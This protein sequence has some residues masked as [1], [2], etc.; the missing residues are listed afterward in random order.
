[1]KVAVFIS[2]TPAAKT[3]S[4]QGVGGG[5]IEGIIMA[6]NSC[7]SKRSRQLFIAGAVDPLHEEKLAPCAAEQERNQAAQRR[8]RRSED[9]VEVEVLLIRPHVARRMIRSMGTGKGRRVDEGDAPY[10]PHA[11]RL[12]DRQEP[13]LIFQ[14]KADC[15]FQNC[16][17]RRS[18]KNLQCFRDPCS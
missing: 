12:Q 3:K 1:M 13:N 2:K 7:F 15:P 8:S 5:K 16:P 10:A 14:E 11:E 4:F 18:D 9:H 6:R 17:D